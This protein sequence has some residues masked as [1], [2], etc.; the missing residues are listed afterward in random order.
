MTN[1]TTACAFLVAIGELAF[2]AAIGELATAM[3]AGPLRKP[4]MYTQ[5]TV[6]AFML[7]SATLRFILHAEDLAE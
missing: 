5:N 6:C 1:R 2:L 3:S 7:P 4:Y